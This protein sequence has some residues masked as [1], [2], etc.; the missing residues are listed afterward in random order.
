MQAERTPHDNMLARGLQILEFLARTTRASFG[1][2]NEALGGISRATQSRILQQLIGLGYV[3]RD[4]VSGHYAPGPRL[5]RLT[6]PVVRERRMALLNNYLPL[7]QEL[8]RHY[9]LTVILQELD[10]HGHLVCIQRLCDASTAHM[11]APGF[12]NTAPDEPWQLL[13]MAFCSEHSA[14]VSDDVRQ[15]RRLEAIRQA[16]FYFDDGK[17]RPNFRRLGFPVFD[18]DGNYAGNLGAGG[19]SM[20]LTDEVKSEIIERVQTYYR[21]LGLRD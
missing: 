8:F 11:Q 1:E 9:H 18:G 4:P 14:T 20:D 5:G 15:E 19:T 21:D 7:M 6:P 3:H 12:V 16:G 2:I 10:Q 13:K 17:L